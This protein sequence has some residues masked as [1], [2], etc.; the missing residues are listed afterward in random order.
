MTSLTQGMA[1]AG[2]FLLALL[3]A[4][5]L[6]LTGAGHAVAAPTHATEATVTNLRFV[7]ESVESGSMTR[8]TADWSL[9]DAPATPAGFTIDLPTELSGRGETFPITDQEDPSLVIA[10]C[11]A[12]RTQL[13]C[14]FKE[15]YLAAHPHDLKGDVF[16][17]VRIDLEVES[18][19]EYSFSFGEVEVPVIVTP[20]DRTPCIDDCELHWNNVKSGGIDYESG[21]IGWW[22]RVAAP[23]E[24]MAGGL[25]VTVRDTLVGGEHTLIV[26][27]RFPALRAGTGI[28]TNDLGYE[29]IK[30][31]HEVPR[32]QYTVDPDGTV[33]FTST[34]GYFYEIEFRSRMDD[35][36]AS[37]VYR[38]K[39]EYFINGRK[40][41]EAGAQVRYA[42]GGGSGIGQDVGVFTIEKVLRGSGADLVGD[43][44]FSGIFEVTPPEGA[45][46]TGTWSVKPG[47]KWRSE[48]YPRDSVVRLT[49]D[50]PSGPAN[51]EWGEPEFS[52]N[53]LTLEGG[54][55]TPLVVTNPVDLRTGTFEASKRISGD[56]A[57][58]VPGGATFALEYTYPAG[59][60]FAAGNGTL[61]LPADGTVV[62]S[63][64]LPFGAQVELSEATP[65]AIEGARWGD[66]TIT[67]QRFTV[68]AG[69]P[70][71]VVVTNPLETVPPTTPPTTTPPVTPPVTTP[72]TTTPPVLPQTGTSVW[73][74]PTL[75]GAAV[76]LIAGVSLLRA[77]RRRTH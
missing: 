1:R 10:Q 55:L 9:P 33:H 37:G 38:N 75:G 68:G 41:G 15:D 54:K 31:W 40:D 7:Q 27:D 67:P 53:G 18:E 72:P 52:G 2:G 77:S 49:E 42:G 8:M 73:V 70:V 65:E 39:A 28:T 22:V 34:E 5:S 46:I 16:F 51:V 29:V 63:P 71:S 25:Q 24:G 32:D 76:L 36:G 3:L 19:T 62:R 48:E 50:A 13:H 11:T 60:G 66:A 58:L 20:P 6:S 30:G 74:L 44:E 45:A 17:W 57:G 4:V 14:D 35:A 47:E 21:T 59:D 12:T 64:D 61:T 26:D 23:R 43:L 56:A 69:E